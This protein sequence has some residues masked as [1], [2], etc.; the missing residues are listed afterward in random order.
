M[1]N[2]SSTV[3]RPGETMTFVNNCGITT[4]YRAEFPGVGWVEFVVLPG[5][6]FTTCGTTGTV[7]VHIQDAVVPTGPTG[8]DQTP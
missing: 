2:I 5:A 6:E 8:I 4:T 1:E 3:I 7:E